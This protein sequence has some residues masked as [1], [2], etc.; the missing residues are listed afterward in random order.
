MKKNALQELFMILN[1]IVEEP[2]KKLSSLTELTVEGIF[3]LLKN[4]ESYRFEDA[5][6]TDL[7]KYVDAI[8]QLYLLSAGNNRDPGY[9]VFLA[10]IMD[11]H[12]FDL[13]GF[14]DIARKVKI[15]KCG[16]CINDHYKTDRRGCEEFID[17]TFEAKLH[18]VTL[19][20]L[21]NTAFG[22]FSAIDEDCSLA[23]DAFPDLVPGVLCIGSTEFSIDKPRLLA[24]NNQRT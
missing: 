12:Y 23:H 10:E 2:R 24:T 3:T 11:R 17:L 16:V 22:S 1:E 4:K 9:E 5:T 14:K 18:I 6:Q 7:N 20:D 19:F 8:R 15:K 21:T 13:E